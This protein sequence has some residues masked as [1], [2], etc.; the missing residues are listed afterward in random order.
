MRRHLAYILT[1]LNS[2]LWAYILTTLSHGASS[3]ALHF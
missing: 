3:H 2:I 1:A